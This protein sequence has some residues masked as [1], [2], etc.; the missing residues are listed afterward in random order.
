MRLHY[1]PN[2]TGPSERA[3]LEHWNGKRA[4]ELEHPGHD[5]VPKPIYTLDPEFSEQARRKS[6]EGVVVL[7]LTV[8]EN[9]DV[10]DAV[11]TQGLGYGLDEKALEAVRRWKFQAPLKDGQAI[12]TTVTVEVD[13][14]LSNQGKR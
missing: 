13:F 6:V 4:T 11:V 14:H 9:E 10:T 5:P 7:K 3:A 8:S 1:D 2:W 12:S